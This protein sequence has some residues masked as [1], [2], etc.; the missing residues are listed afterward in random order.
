MMLGRDP[1]APVHEGGGL[2]AAGLAALEIDD[3]VWAWLTIAHTCDAGS[4]YNRATLPSSDQSTCMSRPPAVSGPR[5]SWRHSLWP[6]PH[7]QLIARRYLIR[8]RQSRW[9]NALAVLSVLITLSIEAYYFLLP[10]QKTF[11]MGMVALIAPLCSIIAVL[12]TALSVFSTVAVVG[13]VLGVAALTVVMAVTSGFQGEIRNR[14]IGLNAHVLVLKY[15]LD[16][17]EYDETMQK[18]LA[19]PAVKAASPFVYHEMLLAKDGFRTAGVLVK[20]IDIQ[21]APAVLDMQRW[22]LPEPDGRP[23]SLSALGIDQAPRDGGPPLPG[24]LV[25]RELARRLKLQTGERVRLVSP[26][27]GLDWTGEGTPARRSEDP[28]RVQEFRVAGIFSAGFDEYDRR[29]LMVTLPKAQELVGLGN[30]VTG[31]ELRLADSQVDAARRVG[32]KLVQFLGGPPFRSVDWEELNHN[33]F[34]ALRLQKAVL[35]LVLFLIILVAACN[36]V[37]SLTLLVVEKT[38][39][40]AILRAMG[41]SAPSVASVFR[42]AGMGIGLLGT[43]LGLVMGLLTCALVRRLGY[44]LD[45]K[46]Y[47]IDHLPTDVSWAEVA[48]IGG[49]TLLI[50]LLSTLYPALRAARLRPADGLRMD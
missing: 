37:A 7:E 27:V 40:V 25:G 24:L 9:L 49:M 21:R 3:V 13:V 45:A 42:A 2:T 1:P 14:V 41:M 15:G 39:E 36:I 48:F 16:F 44:L 23:P 22:L 18:L 31:I 32:D 17:Q 11:L 47:M 26:L 38:R 35:T 19:Q 6:S 43:S 46:V 8:Y 50:C 29:L 12:L 5:P 34:T 28:P 10:G 20:G 4:C 30:T 33:L